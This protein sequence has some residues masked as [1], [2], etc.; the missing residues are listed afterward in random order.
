MFRLL[1]E[2]AISGT[3]T[4]VP[5][6]Q[7]EYVRAIRAEGDA[8]RK[9]RLYAEALRVIQPRLAPLIRVLQEAAPLDAE[10]KR[11]WE[12]VAKR[13]A[14]NMQVFVRDLASTSR[15]RPGLSQSKAAD[16]IW[17]MN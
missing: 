1:I 7:R 4:A 6:E 13:R 14:D 10:L 15:L 5:A 9:L 3:D 11:L 16:V 8:A 12:S 17:S 2:T